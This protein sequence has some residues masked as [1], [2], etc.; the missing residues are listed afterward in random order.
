[1]VQGNRFAKVL[2]SAIA[3]ANA[4]KAIR[5]QVD[6]EYKTTLQDLVQKGGSIVGRLLVT[7]NDNV[8]YWINEP[9]FLSLTMASKLPAAKQYQKWV[10][11]EVLPSIHK[12]GQ[13]T[14]AGTHACHMGS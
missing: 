4:T 1:M 11:S 6:E 14:L 9:G 12:T 10:F 5:Q 7:H 8:A 13:Y 3:F 2:G